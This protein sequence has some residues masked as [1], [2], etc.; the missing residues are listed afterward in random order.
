MLNLYRTGFAWLQSVFK[1][2]IFAV[3][4]TALLLVMT[5]FLN[6]W[7]LA[8][9]SWA[10]LLGIFAPFA[11]AA[12]ASTP[13][14]VSGGGGIDISVGP[15][16]ALIAI[17]FVKVLMPNG[18]GGPWIAIPVMLAMGT[19]VG[20]FNGIVISHFRY[21]PV[22]TTISV[23]FVLTGVAL[24]IAP[25]PVAAPSNWTA[26]F[27][28][29]VGF[30][31]GGLITIGMPILIWVVLKR[32]AFVR[33]LFAVG[34][35]DATAYSAGIDVVR[36][37]VIAY[38][39][40]GL[41]A[42]FGAIALIALL[43]SADATQGGQYTLLAIAA[44]ALGGTTLIGGR[45]SLRGAIFGAAAIFLLQDVLTALDVPSTWL[46]SAY[47]AA[48]LAGVIFGARAIMQRTQSDEVR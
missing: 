27:A 39:L 38:S 30:I 40:G 7:I 37:R 8:P 31:P 33:T 26:N 29:W 11:I 17:I 42:G 5:A 45:G 10:I 3:L 1:T 6:P 9:S 41:F 16:M 13:A 24:A 44:V 22:I 34:A 21:P 4:L 36:V 15:L 48:L 35:D 12:M 32:T 19:A 25:I 46:R 28:H 47:G 2:S 18:L 43:Q 20:L 23:N 14:I